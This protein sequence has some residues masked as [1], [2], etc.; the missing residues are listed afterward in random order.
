MAQIRG[1]NLSGN[2]SYTTVAAVAP[3]KLPQGPP[4]QQPGHNESNIIQQSSGNNRLTTSDRHAYY[5]TGYERGGGRKSGQADPLGPGQAP[6]RPILRLINRTIN[7]QA[8]S[9]GR[10]LDNKDRGYSTVNGGTQFQGTQDGNSSSVYGGTPGLY[11]PYGS[12]AGFTTGPIKGIQSPV[13]LGAANDGPQRV[14]GGPPHGLHTATFP[15]A[16][17]SLGRYMAVPQ[18]S[19][20]T[21]SKPSN[22]RIAG[23]SYSQ[24]VAPLGQYGT[25]AVQVTGQGN[26][27]TQ[28][29][30]Q[31][32]SNWRGA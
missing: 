30:F 32:G 31:P 7:Y 24:T 5:D 13:E 17:Q 26:E 14:Y 4:F 19:H 21:G 27:P 1:E 16:S 6:V 10:N 12:Y 2:P 25:V 20:P 23:Q 28:I 22:S 29:G 15:D 8:G 18:M 9:P 11:Q 3:P